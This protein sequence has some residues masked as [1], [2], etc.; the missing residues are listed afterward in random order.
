M[1]AGACGIATIIVLLISISLAI[2]YSSGFSLTQNWLSDLTGMGYTHFE[3][4]S[5]PVVSSPITEILSRSGFILTG[6]LGIIFSTG[7]FYD[8]DAPSHRLGA[9]FTVLGAGALCAVGLFPEPSGLIHIVASYA[10]FLLVPVAILLISGAFIDAS[11]RWLGGLS[12]VLGVVALA[13]VSM[14]S[15]VR[16]VAEVSVIFAIFIWLVVL[17]VRMVWRASH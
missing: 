9:A 14:V 6:I 11:H 12:I 17:S 3:E 13:G 16:G 1:L 5:R 15:Y 4:V 8:D 2:S 7:L 10:V